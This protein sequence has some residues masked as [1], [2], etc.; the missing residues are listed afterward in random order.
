M[1]DKL[2]NALARAIYEIMRD[3][4]GYEALREVMRLGSCGKLRSLLSEH[5]GEDLE[6]ALADTVREIVRE[7]LDKRA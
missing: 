4:L 1:R 2:L 5:V 6:T 3:A 7:E